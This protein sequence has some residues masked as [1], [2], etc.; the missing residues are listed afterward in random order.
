MS[1]DGSSGYASIETEAYDWMR[2]F[3]SGKAQAADLAALQ[4]WSA[5]SAAHREA[6]ERVSRCWQELGPVAASSPPLRADSVA[7]RSLRI[8]RRA[9]LGGALAA[10]AA[11]GAIMVG[12]PPMELWPSWSELAA[13]YRTRPGQQR[14]IT[15]PDNVSIALNTRTAVNFESARTDGPRIQL[16]TG[17]A[18]ISA[19]SKA[20]QPVVVVAADG[21]VVAA[22]ARFNVRYDQNQPVCVTCVEGTLQVER[23]GM[24]VTLSAGRQVAYSEN[25][26]GSAIAVDPA[27]VTAWQQGIVIFRST[28]ISEVVAEV[29]RYRPGRVILTN[30]ALGR[31]E[32]NARFPID[33]IDR[34]VGQIEQVFGAHATT[35]PGGIMLLG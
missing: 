22:E 10:S 15:L 1:D 16:I 30:R 20:V 19:R 4:S 6:F 31:R 23:L 5:R 35:L 18:V 24:V 11:G 25:G 12:R 32:L 28:P 13:D 26:I 8:G 17:E 7:P 21:R 9:F 33:D 2:R 3:S 29:N 27:M 34:V 14:Q